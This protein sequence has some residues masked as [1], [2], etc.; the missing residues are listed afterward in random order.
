MWRTKILMFILWVL[1]CLTTVP[2]LIHHFGYE[3]RDEY[4]QCSYPL[5][6]EGYE[7]YLCKNNCG[8]N[9]VLISTLQKNT[10][11][12]RTYDEKRKRVFI[13]IISK[14][15][16]NDA[17]KFWCGVTRPG[18]DIYTEVKL[19]VTQDRCCQTVSKTQSI[20]EGSVT[21]SCPYDSQSANNLKYLCRGN[22]PSVCLKQAVI[23]SNSPQEGRFRL[24][25]DR[26]SRIF[27][28]TISRLTLKDSGLYLCGV[29]R[30]SDYDLFSAVELDVKDDVL[31]PL[32]ALFPIL[33]LILIT[34]LVKVRKNHCHMIKETKVIINT[35]KLEEA[36]E[37]E[38]MNSNEL[39]E[40]HEAVV[41]Y[42]QQWTFKQRSNSY[43]FDDKDENEADC[44]SIT[45]PEEIYC[46][47]AFHAFQRR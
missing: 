44:E 19:H 12:Y 38:E 39:Y 43:H 6:Y 15:H 36:D 31:Y 40:N 24:T 37:Q 9:D 14:L 28:V 29:K 17:G 2:G 7:K 5:G 33:L 21:I 10:T 20:E 4:I 45:A 34:V 32:W 42:A 11:K 35:H 30:T 3:G 1:S 26:K 23:T 41:V 46:N 8:N 27:T 22:R 47:E 16:L 13:A 18:T 25:D